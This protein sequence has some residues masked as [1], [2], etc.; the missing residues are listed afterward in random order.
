MMVV[1]MMVVVMVVVVMV[2]MLVLKE[3]FGCK[4]VFKGRLL[5]L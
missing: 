2:V 4:T 1:A 3:M 5:T